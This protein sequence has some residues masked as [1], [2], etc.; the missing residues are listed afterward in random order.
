MYH[1]SIHLIF[2]MLAKIVSK[3]NKININ[4]NFLTNC[5][6]NFTSVVPLIPS[7]VAWH[8]LIELSLW[9]K[10]IMF[11]SWEWD[12]WLKSESNG[13]FNNDK[14]VLYALLCRG[15]FHT[16]PHW[17]RIIFEVSSKF[18]SLYDFAIF[19]KKWKKFKTKH[20]P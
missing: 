19:L 10:I 13:D 6:K 1:I 18:L 2:Y 11:K 17:G 9:L 8:L 15:L 20:H 12:C 7:L 14:C 3:R 5:S 16:E 4:L